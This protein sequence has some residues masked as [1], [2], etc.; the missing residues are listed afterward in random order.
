MTERS[1]L[2]LEPETAIQVGEWLRRCGARG[3]A[4]LI[5]E[6]YRS[7]ERQEELYQHGRTAPGPIVTRARAWESAHQFRIAVDAVPV[8]EL[9]ADGKPA[10]DWTPF[11]GPR[12]EL[13]FRGTLELEWLERP[14]RIMAEESAICGLSWSGRWRFVEY[15]HFQKENARPIA[16]LRAAIGKTAGMV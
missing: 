16:E 3:V 14:W 13:K 8:G 1:L 10:L 5:L 6:T 15:C 11:D 9:G 12:R 2:E 4:V 7:P